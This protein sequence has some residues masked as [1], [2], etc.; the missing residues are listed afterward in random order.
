MSIFEGLKKIGSI[1]IEGKAFYFKQASM[2]DIKA[3]QKID[4]GEEVGRELIFRTICNEDGSMIEGLTKEQIDT[5]LPP[6][7][8]MQMA[9]FVQELSMPSTEKKS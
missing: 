8:F 4:D 3:I 5:E 6:S 9:Q 7:Y 1:E 2:L